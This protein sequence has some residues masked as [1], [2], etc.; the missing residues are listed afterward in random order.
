MKNVLITGVSGYLGTRLVEAL[1]LDETIGTIVGIDIAPPREKPDKLVFFQKDIRAGDLG[2]IFRDHRVDTV[3]HLAFVVQPIHDLERM[4]DIDVNGTRNILEHARDCGAGH[5]MV[6]SST[7]AYGAHPDNPEELRETD[8]L[9]GNRSYP[10]GHNKALV[11][12]MI[13]RF[14]EE[15]DTMVVTILRP[16]TVFGPSVD[17]YVSRML[18]R[19][20]TVGLLGRNP[21]IQLI[22]EDDFVTACLLAMR[23][24][25]G[26]AFNIAGD[27]TLTTDE[28]AAIVGTRVIKLPAWLLRPVLEV[29]W[30]LRVPGVEV[31]H[32]YLDYAGHPFV[33]TAR[34]AKTEL[35]F[36]P[37]YTTRETLEV[38]IR[39]RTHHAST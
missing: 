31:N 22:H 21:R 7:L 2:E 25:R 29:L 36:S 33:A 6:T 3:L 23:K 1:S 30:R 37:L 26:G 24:K 20:M 8:P 11:D 9:R 16:C 10:Y 4:H 19:P 17:N 12:R 27:G 14:A 38:T 39:S 35:G 18:F 32:G 5:V 13:Q 34:K 28:V 15:N